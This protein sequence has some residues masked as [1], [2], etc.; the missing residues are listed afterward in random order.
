MT[1]NEHMQRTAAGIMDA[2]VAKATVPLKAEIERL[3]KEKA[4]LHQ[5]L[6]AF[7]SAWYQTAAK[8]RALLPG[9][10][11]DF[12]GLMIKISTLTTSGALSDEQIAAAMVSVGLEPTDYVSLINNATL[13]AKLDAAIEKIFAKRTVV[14]PAPPPPLPATVPPLPPD[15]LRCSIC[16]N[17][18]AATRHQIHQAQIG[19]RCFCGP[20]CRAASKPVPPTIPPPPIPCNTCGTVFSPRKGQRW[21]LSRGRRLYCSPQCRPE[22]QPA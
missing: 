17:P 13:I 8:L 16:K 2:Y 19:Y 1:P 3:T 4:E 7:T 20:A 5:K 14:E 11:V 12:R 6:L 10:P 22:N 15:V 9:S 18:F 21:H